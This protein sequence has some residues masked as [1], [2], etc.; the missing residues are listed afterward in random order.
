MPASEAPRHVY[1]YLTFNVRNEKLA[2]FCEAAA[3][4]LAASRRDTGC[5]HV[6]LHRE[7]SWLRCHSNE[8]YT[9]FVMS[10]EWA[11]PPDVEAHLRSQHAARFNQLVMCN[12]MLATEPSVSLF[13]SPLRPSELA[14]FAQQEVDRQESIGAPT[15]EEIEADGAMHAVDGGQ[16]LSEASPRRPLPP[17][18]S[19]STGAP[20]NS[21]SSTLRSSGSLA[22]KK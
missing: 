10:Q 12:Q 19:P 14:S 3:E 18:A 7:L 2:V 21:R 8:E 22:L 20:G 17:I 16:Q 1:A 15:K 9:L 5:V 13:G 4:L 6:N 11:S